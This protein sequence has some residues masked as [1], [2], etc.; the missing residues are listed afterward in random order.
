M[1]LPNK[2]L[3]LYTR[4]CSSHWRYSGKQNKDREGPDSMGTGHQG[5]AGAPS[6]TRTTKN[7]QGSQL[8]LGIQGRFCRK[9]NTG[10]EGV[11]SVKFWGES[12]PGRG[13]SKAKSLTVV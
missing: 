7:V 11:C 12:I 5:N 4:H 8:R 6:V 2:N 10:W 9:G 13:K 1:H 3:L